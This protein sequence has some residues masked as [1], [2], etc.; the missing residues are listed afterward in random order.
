MNKTTNS[1]QRHLEQSG[2]TQAEFAKQ[3]GVSQATVHDWQA[4]N[5]VPHGKNLHRL[6]KAMS[7]PAVSLLIEFHLPPE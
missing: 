3:V 4:S 1:I 6:A 5:K 7:V 2:L